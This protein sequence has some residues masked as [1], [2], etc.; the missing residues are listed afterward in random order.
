ME[1]AWLELYQKNTS[2]KR[3]DSGSERY[4]DGDGSSSLASKY[5]LSFLVVK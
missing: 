1:K 3:E 2:N 4:E 5:F